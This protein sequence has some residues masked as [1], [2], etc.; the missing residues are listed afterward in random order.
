MASRT[1]TLPAAQVPVVDEADVVVVGGGTSGFVAATAAA[2]AGAARSW[3]SASATS[4]LHY[5]H[6]QHRPRSL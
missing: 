2:R 1:I 5:D 4:G 6:L 3:W